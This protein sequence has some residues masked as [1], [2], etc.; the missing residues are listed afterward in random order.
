[1]GDTD[2]GFFAQLHVY[3]TYTLVGTGE[4]YCSAFAL[5]NLFVN[6]ETFLEAAFL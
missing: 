5:L 4:T 3:L 1:M 6:L 2:H